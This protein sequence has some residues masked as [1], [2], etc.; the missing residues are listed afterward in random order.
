[1]TNSRRSS[2]LSIPFAVRVKRATRR[3]AFVLMLAVCAATAHAGAP[4]PADAARDK[5]ID[6]L[7][8]RISGAGLDGVIVAPPISEDEAIL[9]KLRQAGLKTVLIAPR[10]PP[11]VSLK[12][13]L[14]CPF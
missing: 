12:S 1:M 3:L 7:I 5:E 2:A 10:E 11:L 6:A 9:S 14:T 13:R 4:D 8:E